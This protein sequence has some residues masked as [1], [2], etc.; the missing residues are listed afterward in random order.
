MRQEL[1][2]RLRDRYPPLF[3]DLRADTDVSPLSRGIEVRDGWFDLLDRLCLAINAAL[4]MKPDPA[5]EFRQ[6]KE[7][8]GVLR[9]YATRTTD[10]WITFL[11]DAVRDESK[12]ICENCGAGGAGLVTDDLPWRIRCR[13]CREVK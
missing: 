2:E 12:T 6:I 4:V 7:K 1:E 5:F 11:L 8:F 10:S 3:R 13:D 9:V